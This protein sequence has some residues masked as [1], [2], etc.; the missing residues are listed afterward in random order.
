MV[1]HFNG[2][3]VK[4]YPNL[5]LEHTSPKIMYEKTNQ[6]A[7][8]IS[9]I[10]YFLIVKVSVPG[11]VLPRAALSYFVYYTTDARSDAFQL[12]IPTW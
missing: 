4:T 9:E 10:L 2:I 3:F 11:L 5:G 7:E 8:K 6:L 12:P 1:N